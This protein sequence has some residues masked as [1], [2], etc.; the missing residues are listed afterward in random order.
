MMSFKVL[1]QHRDAGKPGGI[2]AG[3]FWTN[4]AE[5]DRSFP[6]AAMTTIAATGAVGGWVAR[7]GLKLADRIAAAVGSPSSFMIRWARELV[8]DR[9]VLIYAPPLRE[10]LGPRLGPVRLFA[11]QA[12]LWRAVVAALPSHR[13]EPMRIRIFPRG[14]LTYAPQPVSDSR[15]SLNGSSSRA[16]G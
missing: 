1:L 6:M 16:G 9:T 10:R 4:P 7:R 8:V 15:A 14:G 5:I 2:L 3:F 12:D 13:N 11:D